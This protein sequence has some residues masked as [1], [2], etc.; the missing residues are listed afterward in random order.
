[1]VLISKDQVVTIWTKQTVKAVLIRRT[2]REFLQIVK[3]N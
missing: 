3:K 1:M 2:Q